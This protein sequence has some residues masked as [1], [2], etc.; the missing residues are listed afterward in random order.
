M[1]AP[2]LTKSGRLLTDRSGS[3]NS[4]GL[5]FKGKLLHNPLTDEADYWSNG[6]TVGKYF[7]DEMTQTL[8]QV[9]I[10]LAS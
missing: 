9:Q 5:P 4:R 1:F 6:A 7:S 8:F 3:A 10:W 2:R